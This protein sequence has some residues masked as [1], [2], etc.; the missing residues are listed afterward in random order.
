M[1]SRRNFFSIMMMMAVLIFMFQF[2]QVI[3]ENASNYDINEYAASEP[4]S[5]GE[6]WQGKDVGELAVFGEESV[7]FL[8]DADSDTGRMVAE[9][10]NYTKRDL[11]VMAGTS[12]YDSVR[13]GLPGLV[14]IDSRDV[15]VARETDMLVELARAGTPL[16]FCSLPEPDVIGEREEL[17]GLLGIT[18]IEDRVSVQGVHLFSGFL[19]GGEA[20]YK[21]QTEEEEKKQ[22]LEL[23]IPWYVTGKGTKTY[24]VGMLNENQV[25][26]EDFPR[27]IWRNSYEDTMVFAVNGDY[28]SGDAGLGILDAMMY[29]MQSYSV[30]PVVNAQNIVVADFPNLAEENAAGLAAVY[31]R[32]PKAAIQDIMLPGIVSMSLNN[33]LRLTCFFNTKYDYTDSAQPKGEDIP[34]YLQQMKEINAEAGRSLN[35]GEETALEEK[36]E[37]DRN[38]YE[39]AGSNYRFLAAYTEKL[40]EDPERILT[41]EAGLGDIRTLAVAEGADLPLLSYC[42][43]DVTLQKITNSACEYSYSEDLRMR[44]IATALGYSNVL[45]D[46]HPVMWPQSKEDQWE[47]YFDEVFSNV[48]TYWTRYDGFEYTN[49]SESDARLRSFLNLDYET[50]RESDRISLSVEGAGGDAWFILR[51][52]GEAVRSVQNGEYEEL[53]TGAYLIHATSDQVEIL[54]QRAGD[55]LEYT[56]PFGK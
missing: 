45:I 46:M 42:G 12:A 22:D 37:S 27:I 44:S 47:Q 11:T 19:L 38:F 24:M 54:L 31:S 23:N 33:R 48:S 41:A 55:V 40:P 52:H 15:D 34:F 36:L 30:Y 5:G 21:A 14:L 17:A 35:C 29:E 2:S 8:G 50:A 49:L 13:L 43:E 16:I 25:E 4:L 1:V 51:L 10:C 53:E 6:R 28:M 39:S 26:R 32:E 18:R 56:G 7:L 9:W 3:K 20:V